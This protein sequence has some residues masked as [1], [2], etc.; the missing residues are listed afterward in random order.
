M[1]ERLAPQPL[2]H[3][4]FQELAR[5]PMPL[6]AG[7][8]ALLPCHSH[9]HNTRPLVAGDLLFDERRHLATQRLWSGLILV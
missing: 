6:D 4:S 9:R 3:R 8:N 1:S 5:M 2:R 7:S